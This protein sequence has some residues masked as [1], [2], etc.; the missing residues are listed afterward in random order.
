MAYATWH[1]RQTHWCEKLGTE[2]A[3]LEQRVYP[4]DVMPDFP[5]AHVS[6][7]KCSRGIDCNLAGIP[8]PWAY[9]SFGVDPFKLST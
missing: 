1:V 8:C 2:A 3:L 9:S 5:G 6:G 4:N 7:R